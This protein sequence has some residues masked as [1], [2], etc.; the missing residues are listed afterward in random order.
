MF[1]LSAF[2]GLLMVIM[3][4]QLYWLFVGGIGFIFG[5]L[6][7]TNYYSG[8]SDWVT[9]FIALGEGLSVLYSPILSKRL[10]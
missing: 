4:R 1:I 3:G 5:I 2:I 9:V 6:I 8:Y 10:Q 7:A